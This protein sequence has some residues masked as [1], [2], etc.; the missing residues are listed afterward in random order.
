M[1]MTK[2]HFGIAPRYYFIPGGRFNPFVYAGVT[3]NYTDVYYEDNEYAAC[4][5]LERLD[6]YEENTDL[7][8]WFEYQVGI[9]FM[10]GA[11]L[12]YSL[13]D[14]CGAPLQAR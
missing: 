2:L 9:G 14:A 6:L 5:T 4:E 1:D 7:T 3:L 12:D 13:N 8:E 11:G 10:A